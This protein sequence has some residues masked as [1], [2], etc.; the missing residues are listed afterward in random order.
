MNCEFLIK[1]TC[2]HIM[3]LLTYSEL[4]YFDFYLFKALLSPD[5]TDAVLDKHLLAL[6]I[7]QKGNVTVF[8]CFLLV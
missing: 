6:C 2:S 4:S 1:E 3:S 5:Y 7:Y 8:D